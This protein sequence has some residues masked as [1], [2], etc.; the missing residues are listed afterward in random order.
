[1][2]KVYSLQ[3]ANTYINNNTINKQFYP[4]LNFAAPIGWINDPNGLSIF[5]D[6]LHLFYQYYPYDSIHGAMHWGHAKSTNGIN[7]TH[8]DVALAPDEKYDKNGV[9]SG[10]AIEKDNKHYLMYTGHVV[11][12]NGEITENQNI[13]ISEDGVHFEKY[14][15]NP[16][17]NSEDVPNGSSIEDFR[18]PKIFE[19]NGK[20]YTLLGSRTS[21][22]KGQVLLYESPDLLTWQFKSVIFSYNHFLGEMVECP[23]LL[24]FETKDVF[25]LSAM[26][27][28]DQETGKVYP[29]ISWLIEEKVNWDN[30][31][32]EMTSIRI[33]DGGFD[34]YAPQ[35][36]LSSEELKEYIAVAWQ[37]AWNRTLPSHERKHG[38]SGQ[39]TIPRLL[40]EDTGTI[41]QTPYPQIFEEI[42]FTEKFNELTLTERTSYYLDSEYIIFD[43]EQSEEV[44]ITFNNNNNESVII[45]FDTM[46]HQ[47]R[48]SRK[49]TIEIIDEDG[50][51]FT[52]KNYEIPI[53]NEK[54][55]VEI[56][57]DVSSIQIFIGSQY[58]FTS[59][60]YV[61]KPFDQIIFESNYGSRINN[62]KFGALSKDEEK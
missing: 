18:D 7:W 3:N 6:E 11:D 9:F 40:K 58:T 27:Y 41:I 30:F 10:S 26:N 29:H 19:R 53:E 21:D 4:K 35:T 12:E 39:M 62:L 2:E 17:I 31:K 32:F 57:I 1:M 20:Y 14:M 34:F 44:K 49:E 22:R 54:W 56:F 15:H 24:F 5:Q 59:T 51:I 50:N 45:V 37:Q 28:K 25:L 55:N 47:L 16:V 43:L 36:T 33:M 60:Y 8:L 42:L 46:K 48:F 61:E 52:E 38:W 23:D 13:A